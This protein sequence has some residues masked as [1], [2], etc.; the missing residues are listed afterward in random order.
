LTGLGDSHG[1]CCSAFFSS[2]ARKNNWET[3]HQF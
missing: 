3:I 2:G 1:C